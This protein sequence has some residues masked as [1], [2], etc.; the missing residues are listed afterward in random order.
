MN[1]IKQATSE[2]RKI[3]K[4]VNGAA[5]VRKKNGIH[6]LT[7][8]FIAE[9]AR[10]VKSYVF[11]EVLVPAIKKAIVD[12]VTDG[13]NMVFFGGAG[14]RKS[15]GQSKVSYGSYY[16]QRDYNYRQTETPTQRNRFDHDDIVFP[17]R[18]DAEG[19]RDEMINVID[20]YGFVTVADMYDMAQLSQPYTSDKYGWT[21][22]RTT[23]VIRVRDGYILKLPK[24]LPIDQ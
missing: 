11:G 9:D 22:L 4:V 15:S 12:I 21:N 2:E 6:N 10:N 3:E 18:G 20:R 19:V 5:K 1:D 7:S 17:T 16:N 14:P 13:V 23:E 8:V 24:A